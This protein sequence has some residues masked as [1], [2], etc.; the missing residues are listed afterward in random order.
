[1]LRLKIVEQSPAWIAVDKPPGFHAHPP[2][3]KGIRLSRRWNALAVLEKQLGE[4]LFPAH[5]LDR[6]ASGILLYSRRRECNRALQ[7]QFSIGSVNKIY[8]LL[9]R[10]EFRGEDRIDRP[11]R[12][13]AGSEQAAATSVS[14]CFS[15]SLPIPHP[16]GGDRVFTLLVAQPLTGR[17]HQIRRH[18]AG[19]GFPLI[20]DSRHGDRK[21][22]REFAS[23]TGCSQLFL[24]CMELEFDCPLEGKRVHAKGK[25][26]GGW[27]KIFDLAG[28]CPLT[29]SPFPGPQTLS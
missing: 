1:M 22:N 12:N 20:G 3:D 27:H 5:R 4:T 15:F 9:V 21:L 6:A 2:E 11:L 26:S 8:Y 17:F 16:A 19:L 13:E 24:R 10:G 23:L 14:A 18:L 25:W 7:E 29:T 28:A